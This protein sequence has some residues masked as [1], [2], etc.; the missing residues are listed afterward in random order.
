M[1]IAAFIGA[2]A[3]AQT[4][5]PL[6]GGAG[7]GL[8]P[9][10]FHVQ[11]PTNAAENQ[12]YWF[13][14]NIYHCL[15]FSNDGAFEAGNTTLPRTEQRFEPD[16]TNGGTAPIGEIQY[17]SLE[18][19]PSNENSYCVFQIHTGDAESDAYG[20]TTFMLFW[21]TNNNGSVRDYSGTELV[22]GL[23][24]KW[25]QLNVDHSLVNHTIRA[26][27]NQQSVWTQQDNGAGDFYFKDGCY[28]QSHGPSY[29]MDTYIT[30]I[31]MWTNSGSAAVL[32]APRITAVGLNGTTLTLRATNGT[33]GGRY[34]LLQSTNVAL[35]LNQWK[36]VL[37]N[38]FDSSGNLNIATN[39]PGISAAE[40]YILSQ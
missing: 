18:M 27:I 7:W 1:A 36:P 39:I 22:K 10:T 9:V 33:D 14:N 16:Y 25:F 17:Q 19:A 13:T 4:P 37:T 35:P 2:S 15:V 24:N 32:R 29:E 5:Q 11:W 26:W 38:T 40:F 20:S 3:L 34:V 31:L 12:R 23:G 21:F 30:N 28:E 8:Y 6:G